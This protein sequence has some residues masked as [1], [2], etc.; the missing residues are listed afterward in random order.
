M[1]LTASD[2]DDEVAEDDGAALEAV[3]VLQARD[4]RTLTLQRAVFAFLKKE[5]SLGWSHDI[6]QGTLKGEVSLYCWPPV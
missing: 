2:L 5:V 6:Q 4:R 3:Q 1:N